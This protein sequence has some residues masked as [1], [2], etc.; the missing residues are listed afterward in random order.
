MKISMMKTID[1]QYVLHLRS[2][3]YKISSTKTSV[4][5]GF[6]LYQEH[7]PI[8]LNSFSFD[9]IEISMTKLFN[10][11]Y[12]LHYRSM[13]HAGAPLLN[14]SFPRVPRVQQRALWFGR[15]HCDQKIKIKI[16]IKK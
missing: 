15:S 9:F 3:S 2:K 13:N 1:L 4:L 5:R 11:H 8:C 10:I 14:K 12:F 16:E 6:Q 7:A